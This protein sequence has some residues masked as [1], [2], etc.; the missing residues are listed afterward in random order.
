MIRLIGTP[1]MRVV[2]QSAAAGALPTLYAA[3]VA[4]PGSY[5]GPQHLGETRGDDR[6]GPAVASTPATPGWPAGSGA[7]ART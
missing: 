3:T 7:S 2:A 6:S 5:T 4:A 1:V